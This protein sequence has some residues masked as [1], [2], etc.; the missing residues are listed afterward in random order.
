MDEA[1][2]KQIAET[3]RR[4]QAL[5]RESEELA[6]RS[7]RL[8]KET[9]ALLQEFRSWKENERQNPRRKTGST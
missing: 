3:M 2:E 6:N 9:E 5:T 1:L 8:R 4:S 7:R